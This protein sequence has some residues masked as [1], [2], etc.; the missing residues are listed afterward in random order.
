MLIAWLTLA[1]GLALFTFGLHTTNDSIQEITHG[2]V[3][4]LLLI[5]AR[6][7]LASALLGMAATLL[8]GSSSAISVIVVGFVNTGLLA[9]RQALDVMLGAAVGTTLT[10]QL[11][12]LNITTYAPL[13]V[14]VAVI[15]MLAERRRERGR[16][17]PLLL[18]L[19][20]IFYGMNRIVAAV[21]TL[22]HLAW[23]HRSLGALDHVPLLAGLLA[24]LATAVIQNS[25]TVIALAITFQVHHLTTLPVGLEM[26]LGANVGST[27]ASMYTA[28]LAGSRAAK[29]TA[30]AYFFMKLAGA[31]V[32]TGLLGLYARTVLAVETNP[33]RTLADAH[34]LFN[35]V[36]ALAFLPLTPI[37]A[38]TMERLA[39]DPDP[40]PVTRLNPDHL[41]QPELALPETQAEIGRM[42]HLI[43]ERLIG[44]LSAFLFRPAEE[45]ER[46]IRDAEG[47]IDILHDAITHY[48]VRLGRHHPLTEAARARQI[49]LFYLVNRLEHLSDTVIKVLDTR[50][51]LIGR[52]FAWTPALQERMGSLVAA[53]DEHWRAMAEAVDRH[54]TDQARALVQANPDLRRREGDVRVYILTHGDE[55][56]RPVL[57]A[58]LELSDDLALLTGRMGDVGRAALG[59]V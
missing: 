53:L 21:H 33:L 48:L 17:S 54:D 45:L 19:G 18:G 9:L 27:A 12:A 14:L 52:D 36:I 3:R 10:V 56:S 55:F 57:S 23:V 28:F 30:L 42:A 6:S 40:V 51:K 24:F 50:V 58:V 1:G 31:V 13:L 38:R 41:D 11:I 34:T 16:F 35:L 39:P 47:E 44:P 49:E 26:V 2:F 7:P 4:S 43:G 5:V 20:F 32:F 22:A 8:A 25:A 37:L 29:R 59:I 15:W 46:R